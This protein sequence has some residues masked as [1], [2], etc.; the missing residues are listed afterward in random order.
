MSIKDDEL[1]ILEKI[2]ESFS[3][4]GNFTQV[5]RDSYTRL[6]AQYEDINSR[7][8]RVNE[9]LRSSLCE[10]N[11]LTHYLN[12]ILESLDSAVIVTDQ[13]G[14]INVFNSAAEKYTGVKA[15]SALGQKLDSILNLGNS[16]RALELLISENGAATG[17]LNLLAT[18]NPKPPLAYSITRLRQESSEDQSGLVII[19]YNLSEIK[20]LEDNLKQVSTLAALGEM[21]AT[22]AHEIRNPLSGIAGFTALLLRDL[23]KDSPDRRLVEKINQGVTSLNSIVAS[24][25]DYTRSV[26]PSIAEVD[27]VSVISDAVT[28]LQAAEKVHSHSIKV[29]S[30]SR[31]LTGQSRSP[32][33]PDGGI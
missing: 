11:R 1:E 12:N 13:A 8:A 7:L 19:L 20:R 14:T 15:E 17:E 26:T 4:M 3:T 24:L 9:L 31:H 28:D 32:A 18:D 21:A 23:D 27:A 2:A 25:L 6:E 30:S 16:L 22:V 33:F 10:R 29:E 5:L